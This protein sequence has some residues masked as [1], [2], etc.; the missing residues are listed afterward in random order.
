MVTQVVEGATNPPSSSS[1][2]DHVQKTKTLFCA[3]NLLSRDL[4]LPPEVFATVS[5][6]YHG[7]GADDDPALSPSD[8][9]QLGDSDPK[10]NKDLSGISSYGDLIMEFEDAVVKQ[11]PRCISSS[12][13]TDLNESRIQ[14]RVEHRLTELEELPASR[15]EDLQSKCLLELYGLKLAELQMKVRSEVSSEYWLRLKCV[16]PEQQL[17]DW[18][19]TRLRRPFY[20]VGHPFARD[21]DDQLRKK[22]DAER[23]SRFEEEEKNYVETRKRKFFADLLNAAREFQLQVGSFSKRRKQRN[24]GVMA[25]HG[26]QRQRATRQEKMRMDALKK[27]DQEAYM[28]MVEESKNERLTM[29][30]G[31]TNE[32]LVSLG[33]AVQRQKDAEHFDGIEPLEESDADMRELDA[34]KEDEDIDASDEDFGKAG[35]LLDGQKK[36]NS[37]VHSIQEKVTEQPSMLQGG[38][39][40]PYQVEGLQWMLS[41]F[42]NNLNGILA[43][44]MGLGKTIQTIAL[45]AYLMEVKNVTG[46]HLIVAPKAVLPNWVHEFQ[47]WVPSI[48]AVLY[49]GRQE[50]RK[51]IREEY[52]AE[53]KFCVMITHYDLIM[54]DKQ[55][56]KKI[57]WYYMIVDEG[58]RLKNH[59]CALARVLVSEYR[60]RRRLLLTGTPIQNSLQELWA[61]LNFLLP[62]I[63]NSVENFAE[64]FNAPFADRCEV[65]LTDEEQLLVIRRLHH[66]IRPFILR[67]KKDEVEKYLPG[68]TQVIL[69]CDLSAWQKIYYQQVTDIGRVG[70][71][72]ER[73]KSKGLQNLSMQLR[74]CCNH[75]YLFLPE[76]NIWR[77]EEIVRASG[78]FELLDRLLP[79]LYKSGHRVLLFSQMTRLLDILEVYLRMHKYQF[80]RLDGSSKTDERGTLL[81]EFNAPN[82]P[83]FIFL[84]STRAGGLGLNLQTADTVIIF[85]SDW[86]P[87]MDQ[88]AEDR[89]HRIGQKKEVRVFVLVSVGSIEEVILERA[90][91]KMGID[92]KVIQA[93]L[94]NTTS[95]AQDRKEML[96]VIMRRGTS[97]LGTD[98]PSEREINRLAARTD[99]EFWL[100]EKMDEDRR[101]EENYRSRLMEDHEVPEW[102]YTINTDA[103][104]RSKGFDHEVGKITGKRKRKEVVYADS[105][106]DV[107]WVKAVEN[108][109]DLSKT[110]NKRKKK[111]N[112]SSE[113]FNSPNNN[114][115]HGVYELGDDDIANLSDGKSEE[116][117]IR[118]NGLNFGTPEHEEDG[119]GNGNG[120][121]NES[122]SGTWKL[123]WKTHK[124]KR[125]SFNVM[126]SSSMSESCRG[127]STS[128]RGNRW[129]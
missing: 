34:S 30:L 7:D 105:L 55:Y 65:A 16:H 121:G 119:G 46:P 124:K 98:I 79:K 110:I 8:G 83:Y 66:V 90:K 52:F 5:S 108:G 32:L 92:A 96:E 106:S 95:T 44:E 85:D 114:N 13:L 35:N 100:F 22:R 122:G 24:D 10:L 69:K 9:A 73:G 19:M 101:Q 125:S 103:S 72:S 93:G 53:E 99:E 97:A 88:Q 63:F 127:Q 107:K 111:E 102:V 71:D 37:A 80:L 70:M 76:Y 74:K 14:S 17:F 43:D 89:A 20:G 26:R 29:L 117:P 12:A 104:E 78:K 86:N 54:R 68:K 18:G 15:G 42:N 1:T 81:K 84:L 25:W 109:E 126:G 58:H 115:N 94:F 39:L 36:Y 75:P 3:L 49:D 33:A 56:L 57:H 67:R 128:G 41:L 38:E 23:L 50:T 62:Q 31:K 113:N 47:T 2:L 87:Q 11:R 77:T 116:T 82:S 118:M 27:D 48:V 129:S 60:I 120:N 91:Q 59:E 6:I 28:K 123:T 40:R 4:P 61:L 21:A 112:A 64:W 45:I 51:A